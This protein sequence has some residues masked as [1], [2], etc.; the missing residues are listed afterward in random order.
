MPGLDLLLLSMA[1]NGTRR[2]GRLLERRQ[3]EFIGIGKSGLLATG[4][5]YADT[6]IQAEAALADDAIFEVPALLAADLIPV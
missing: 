3:D 6:L 1:R 5:A 2:A 4:G